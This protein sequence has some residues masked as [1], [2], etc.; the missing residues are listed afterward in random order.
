MPGM[1]TMPFGHI[2]DGNVHYNVL[3]PPGM[4]GGAFLA[5]SGAIAD[6]V[7]AVV[8]DL[9]GSFAAE[10]G[11]GRIKRSLMPSWR[12]GTELRMMQRIKAALD[13][14]GIMNPGV[15]LP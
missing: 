10:H 7:H 8:R 12:G 1:R 14:H 6:A 9:D 5:Q 4:T 15:L 3:A 2:G 13:P 11:V